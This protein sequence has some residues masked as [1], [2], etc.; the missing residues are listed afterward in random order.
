MTAYINPE[1]NTSST[2]SSDVIPNDFF[3]S[4]ESSVDDINTVAYR[5][6]VSESDENNSTDEEEMEQ[7][8]SNVR[9]ALMWN[10][11]QIAVFREPCAIKRIQ[12]G[13]NPDNFVAHLIDGTIQGYKCKLN[14]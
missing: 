4:D 10:V 6:E 12:W 8:A 1:Q 5:E 3:R 9:K 13:R 2:L 7:E 14:F 11:R